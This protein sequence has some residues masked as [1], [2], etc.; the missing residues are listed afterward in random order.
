LFIIVD[1]LCEELILDGEDRALICWSPQVQGI[2]ERLQLLQAYWAM[3]G[4]VE[5]SVVGAEAA[6]FV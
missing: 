5:R 1:V 2:K 6:G 3:D 4:H